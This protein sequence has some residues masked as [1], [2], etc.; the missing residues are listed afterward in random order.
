MNG[1]DLFVHLLLRLRHYPDAA[2]LWVLIK[3]RADVKE[4]KTTTMLMSHIQLSGTIDR[5]TAHRS[6]KNLQALGLVNVRIH[7][8]TATLVAVNRD[9][10]LDLLD[11]ELEE[12]LPGL[13]QKV[14]PF[15]DAWV[16][17]QQARAAARAAG[18]PDA[19]ARGPAD[20]QAD[21]DAGAAGLPPA[22]TRH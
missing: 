3:E 8:K 2:V 9:A 16:A 13:S 1:S 11:T 12:R 7:R 21:D 22:S 19:G 17:N 18:R 10:V 20:D 5:N 6:I 14:F 15:L 4:F